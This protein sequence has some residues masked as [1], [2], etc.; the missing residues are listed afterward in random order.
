MNVPNL[1]IDRDDALRS[2]GRTYVVG[3]N[4]HLVMIVLCRSPL[5][6]EIMLL[7]NGVPGSTRRMIRLRPSPIGKC[8]VISERSV[9]NLVMHLFTHAASLSDR[10]IGGT[11]FR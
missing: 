6:P 2:A 4:F 7:P 8:V 10:G 9:D 1:D 3:P 11:G 5:T